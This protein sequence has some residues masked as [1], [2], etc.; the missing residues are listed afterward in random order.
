MADNELFWQGV[1]RRELLLPWCES[2]GRC[3]FYPRSACPHCWSEDLTWRLAAGT[4]TVH[5]F[6]TVRANP[7]SAFAEQLPFTIAVVELDEGVR[8]LTNIV[9]RPEDVA[10]GDRVEVAFEER[11]GQVLPMFRRTST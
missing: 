6:V 7:P 9:G 4:G 10:I 1:R 11:A 2:C 5:T 8:M 3:H